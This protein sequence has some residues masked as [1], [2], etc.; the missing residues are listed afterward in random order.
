VA[1]GLLVGVVGKV[2]ESHFH[3]LSFLLVVRLACM[4]YYGTACA[5]RQMIFED[6]NVVW[7]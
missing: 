3:R 5:V 6:R 7:F 1:D 4:F 2:G